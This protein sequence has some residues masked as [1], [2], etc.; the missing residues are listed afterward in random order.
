MI[1]VCRASLVSYIMWESTV[2]YGRTSPLTY[3][4]EQNHSWSLSQLEYSPHAFP[5]DR[6]LCQHVRL[7]RLCERVAIEMG[8]CDPSNPGTSTDYVMQQQM[9]RNALLDLRI[10]VPQ[11]LQQP[12][13]LLF[14][15]HVASVYIEEAVLHTSTNGSSFTAPY[16]A[17]R[18]SVTDF[19][20]PVDPIQYTSAV[21]TLLEGA[22]GALDTLS[23]L[24]SF[25]VT[26][27]PGLIY[28]ARAAYALYI[29][30]KLY[31]A[32]TGAGNTYGVILTGQ[33]IR[34]HEY[35]DLQMAVARRVSA[36]DVQS[37][38]ARVLSSAIRMNEWVQ[39]YDAIVVGSMLSVED[40][41]TSLAMG[42][43]IGVDL[44]GPFDIPLTEDVDV[45][46]E[47]FPTS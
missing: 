18:L 15:F 23:S 14:L 4:T 11:S 20:K 7:A 27:L 26:N 2:F 12:S 37:P 38:S 40:D 5:T 39:N 9:L 33:D 31:I 1:E 29:L 21:Y 16:L 17:E 6:L 46:A 28:A 34:V 35:L 44:L 32:C 8:Y 19:P 30:V 22:Q 45:L 41:G 43:A 13:Q 24:N 3:W 42:D 47:L 36:I 10:T 25:E